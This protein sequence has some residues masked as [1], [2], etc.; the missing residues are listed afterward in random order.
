[1]LTKTQQIS[2]KSLLIVWVYYPALGHLVEVLDCDFIKAVHP[3]DDQNYKDNQE[4]LLYDISETFDYVVFPKR[5]Y[6]TPQDYTPSL[7]RCN[8]YLQGYFKSRHWSGF[9][10]IPD[11]HPKALKAI[12]YSAFKI[13]VPKD[14]LSFKL[15]E[16]VG[17]PIVAVMLKGASKQTIWPSLSTWRRLFKAIHRVYPNATFIITGLSKVHSTKKRTAIEVK[18]HLN[19]FIKSIPNAIFAYDIGLDNQLGIIQQAD[20]FLSPHTGFA[21]LAPCLG[22]P[23]LC[24]RL[25]HPLLQPQPP[26]RTDRHRQSRRNTYQ[27]AQSNEESQ[28]AHLR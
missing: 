20:V 7:L 4:G 23:G 21:F 22:T 1:M 8:R 18:A 16:T 10:D 14:K 9:N 19:Q 5:L 13:Q 25:P 3:I 27:M 24:T 17:S 26:D 15:P 11:S 28:A 2:S 12:P 6:Y